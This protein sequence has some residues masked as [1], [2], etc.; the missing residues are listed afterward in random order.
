MSNNDDL[1]YCLLGF[2]WHG[3]ELDCVMLVKRNGPNVKQQ[4]TLYGTRA[5]KRDSCGL[6]VNFYAALG[7]LIMSPLSITSDAQFLTSQYFSLRAFYIV[8]RGN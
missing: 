8:T 6:P 4:M 5:E 7:Y 1:L 2:P 3:P